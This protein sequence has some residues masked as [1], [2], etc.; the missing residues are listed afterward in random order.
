MT[1]NEFDD[2]DDFLFDMEQELSDINRREDKPAAP[3]GRQAP[4]PRSRSGGRS[5]SASQRN[6][7]SSSRSDSS[8]STASRQNSSASRRSS[9]SSSNSRAS[10]ASSASRSR[11]PSRRPP[12]KQPPRRPPRRKSGCASKLIYVI[13]VVAVSL[14]LSTVIWT[15]ANDL[16]ALDKEEGT[17]V[18][19]IEENDTVRSVAKQ[20]HDMG[21]IRR[22]HLFM[23]YA[24]HTDAIDKIIPG[25]YELRTDLDYRAIVAAMS[26]SSAGRQVVT[27]TIPEGYTLEQIFQLLDEKGVCSYDELIETAATHDY[28]FSFLEEI[29]LGDARRLEGYL[30]PDTY[31]FYQ[32]QSALY[33]INKMLVNFDAKFTDA[34]RQQAGDMG[35]SVHDIVI[36]ASII[37]R[38]TTGL[39]QANIASVIYNR[40]NSTYMRYLQID[41]TVRYALD[42]WTD[43]LTYDD[44]T[45]DSPYNTYI[46]PGLPAGPISNPGYAAI[47]AAL[48]PASTSYYFYALDKDGNHR[49]FQT[50]ESFNSFINSSEAASQ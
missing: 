6:S 32:N 37:E 35:Y 2:F 47:H 29:P 26:Y 23:A 14:I 42:N 20:L 7:H 15:A 13:F 10:S 9:G 34:M 38:E 4:P 30:Y 27:V 16:L 49:F 17:A 50:Q 8:R 33:A 36:I 11:Q 45:V 1:S 5:S 19:V 31:D 24:R 46:H 18:I 25:T 44:L 39:D 12:S 3:Q 40:L 22:T 41:A 21:V 28:A 43:P 48:N